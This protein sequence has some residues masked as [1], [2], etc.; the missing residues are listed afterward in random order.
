MPP[1]LFQRNP[2]LPFDPAKCHPVFFTPTLRKPP[3]PMFGPGTAFSNPVAMGYVTEN[4][5]KREGGAKL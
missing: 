3:F 4:G 1:T 2:F 5:V